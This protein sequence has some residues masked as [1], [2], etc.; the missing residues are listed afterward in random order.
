M[1]ALELMADQ[2]QNM[3]QCA[4]EGEHDGSTALSASLVSESGSDRKLGRF[5]RSL[6]VP[7]LD[8]C[9]RFFFQFKA[10][11]SVTGRSRTAPRRRW[12][13]RT[14]K[15]ENFEMP[16]PDARLRRNSGEELSKVNW[17]A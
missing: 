5:E 9:I 12:F 8:G 7:N 17:T 1:L 11:R 14:Q 6:V 3:L 16:V 15:P 13:V 2:S 10:G 4:S